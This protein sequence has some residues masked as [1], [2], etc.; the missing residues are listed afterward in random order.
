MTPADERLVAALQAEHAA[1]YA[2]GIAGPKLDSGTVGVARNAEAAHRT[3][4]DDLVVRLSGAGISPPPAAPAYAL[5]F[6]VTD[7]ASALKLLAMVEDRT[8]AQWRLALPPTSGDVRRLAVDALVDCAA[9]GA[10]LRQAAGTTPLTSAFP[11]KA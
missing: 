9:R 11:G 1:I 8:A 10:A 4:R 3:R 5:P 6:P 7:R 2:Y